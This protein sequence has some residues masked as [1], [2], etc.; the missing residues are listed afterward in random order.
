M[1][2][3]LEQQIK[4]HLSCYK[5]DVL[6][7]LDN[8]IWWKNK[9]EYKHILPKEKYEQNIIDKGFRNELLNLIKVKDLHLGFHHLN[10]SQAL[11]LNLFGPLIIAKQISL[12]GKFLGIEINNYDQSQF[13]Y[14]ENNNENT[15]FDFFIKGLKK[16]YFEIK[17]T[18]DKFGNA[19][20]DA[21]H[22]EKYLEIYK[23]KLENITCITQKEFF[24]LYQLWRNIMYSEN[25]FVVFILPGFRKDLIETIN[26]AKKQLNNSENIKIIKI[27]EIVDI[28]KRDEKLKDHYL[29]F[30]K[31]YLNFL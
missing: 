2:A 24:K 18:E 13:E 1:D 8:G 7:I 31:K 20:D 16:I 6:K 23:D 5:N 30:E 29:E 4:N 12:I 9:K 14:I 25:G 26:S 11:A 10:S 17:Y 15:N 27:E 22:R 28:C 3:K 19:K 21:K